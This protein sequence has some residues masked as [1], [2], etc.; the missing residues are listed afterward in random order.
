[1]SGADVYAPNPEHGAYV[2]RIQAEI[3]AEAARANFDWAI[4]GDG[5]D[6]WGKHD[7]YAI[8]PERGGSARSIT[9]EL[10]GAIE[11]LPDYRDEARIITRTVT[12]GPWRYVTPEE[13]Q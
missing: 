13:L 5:P 12:Y 6:G 3:A 2:E 1:M 10:Y 9:D 8:E 11:D 4:G 7:E